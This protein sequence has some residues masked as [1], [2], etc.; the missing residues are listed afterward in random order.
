M[1]RSHHG[2]VEV[3][4]SPPGTSAPGL[5]GIPSA[6][7]ETP[8][9]IPPAPYPEQLAAPSGYARTLYS[10]YG[11]QDSRGTPQTSRDMP[12]RSMSHHDEGYSS[13]PHQGHSPHTQVQR[14]PCQ[15]QG[16]PSQYDPRHDP[17]V[18]SPGYQSQTSTE[19]SAH[20]YHRDRPM[21]SY[22]HSRDYARSRSQPEPQHNP[23]YTRSR[24]QETRDYSHLMTS[25]PAEGNEYTQPPVPARNY[26]LN[27]D[28]GGFGDQSSRNRRVLSSSS[29]FNVPRDYADYRSHGQYAMRTSGGDE[30]D[31][32]GYSQIL[33]RSLRDQP[34][35]HTS[36]SYQ[37]DTFIADTRLPGDGAYI[38]Q[39]QSQEYKDQGHSA[40]HPQ[41]GP[42]PPIPHQNSGSRHH[43]DS[44]TQAHYNTQQGVVFPATNR[45]YMNSDTYI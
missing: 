13:H 34:Y 20:A 32:A 28:D 5:Q 9:P 41:R 40:Y 35:L 2:D 21:E 6:P 14:S 24:S 18:R 3:H 17:N 36:G 19:P 4:K 26:S 30:V 10:P 33:P 43:S 27:D 16:T 38:G 45:R 15:E 31:Y 22:G 12:N 29:H 23:N 11:S 8:S 42:L 44:N 39:G 7:S 1:V 25:H 37:N